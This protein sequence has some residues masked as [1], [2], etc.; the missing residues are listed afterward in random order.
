MG[1]AGLR[2]GF[3]TQRS[4]GGAEAIR[5]GDFEKQPCNFCGAKTIN[6]HQDRY[7]QPLNVK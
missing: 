5:S 4:S 2:P 6:A 3:L 7:N 1:I